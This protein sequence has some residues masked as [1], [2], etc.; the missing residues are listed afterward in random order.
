MFDKSRAGSL[1]VNKYDGNNELNA[2][3]LELAP[4]EDGS[5]S[6]K[7]VLSASRGRMYTAGGQ[8]LKKPTK[9]GGH[10]HLV[11]PNKSTDRL[12]L[13]T[14]SEVLQ[15]DMQN[16]D[17][18]QAIG[19]VMLHLALCHSVIIDNRSGKMNSASPDETALVEGAKKTG[20]A[21]ISKDANGVI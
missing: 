13:N 12:S 6:S 21:F 7:P 15:Q 3:Q 1:K 19:E 5:T 16:P 17:V 2:D 9:I 8:I 10:N 20:Y 11:S 14:I 18:A 4:P